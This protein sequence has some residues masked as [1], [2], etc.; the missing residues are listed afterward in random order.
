MRRRAGGLIKGYSGVR[1][2]VRVSLVEVD[3]LSVDTYVLLHGSG[4]SISILSMR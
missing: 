3:R 4:V 2:I 1:Y